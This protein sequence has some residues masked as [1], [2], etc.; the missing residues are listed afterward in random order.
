MSSNEHMEFTKAREREIERERE[1]AVKSL[2]ILLPY[3]M[4]CYS[5]PQTDTQ[6]HRQTGTD[7]MRNYAEIHH[8]LPNFGRTG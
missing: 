4:L 2:M 8:G 7:R 1:R 6:T 5:I 3:A